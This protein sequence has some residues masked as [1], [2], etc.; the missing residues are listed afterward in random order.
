MPIVVDNGA[1]Q[2]QISDVASTIIGSHGLDALTIRS[3]ASTVGCSTSFVTDFFPDKRSILLRV[4]ADAA[5]RATVRIEAALAADP[6]DLLG[7]VEAYL[8]LDDAILRDWKIY[9]AF[10]NKAAG[11]PDF[12]D[13]Q[14]RWQN[15]ARDHFARLLRR[16]DFPASAIEHCAKQLLTMVMGISI[17]AAF[18]HER[19]SPGQIRRFVRREV[20]TLVTTNNSASEQIKREDMNV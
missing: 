6:R 13:E 9:F 10:W 11:D 2:T 20:G 19:W 15:V 18:D 3:I 4:L 8:P 16:L 7:C 5:H 12:A 17:Q 1:R 14:R